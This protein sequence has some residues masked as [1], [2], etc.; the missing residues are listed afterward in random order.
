MVVLQFH[1]LKKKSSGSRHGELNEKSMLN[2]SQRLEEMWYK[3]C[4]TRVGLDL[5]LD[6]L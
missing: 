4:K 5:M 2:L 6:C 1:T 3:K